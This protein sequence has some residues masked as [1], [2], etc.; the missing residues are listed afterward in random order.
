M[1]GRLAVNTLIV[2]LKVERCVNL[3][4]SAKLKKSHESKQAPPA[5]AAAETQ[6]SKVKGPKKKEDVTD[7]EFAEFLEVH[8]KKQKDKAIWDNDGI[9]GSALKPVATPSADESAEE[10]GDKVAHKKDLSDLEVP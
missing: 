4:D 3:G 7:P 9:D 1:L 5:V 10:Q 6:K 8:S 2:F